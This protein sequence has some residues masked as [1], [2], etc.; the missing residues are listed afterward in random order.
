[1][2]NFEEDNENVELFW[3]QISNLEIVALQHLS[4]L[5]RSK[6][7]T[8]LSYK[9]FWRS[10]EVSCQLQRIHTRE[11]ICAQPTNLT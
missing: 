7:S 11:E 3:F 6:E 10:W 8:H 9:L 2:S 5:V 1:M 4:K